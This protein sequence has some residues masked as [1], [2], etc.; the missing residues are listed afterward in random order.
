MFPSKGS[1]VGPGGR[2]LGPYHVLQIQI[3]AR[4]DVTSNTNV[5][6]PPCVVIFSLLS[7]IRRG[8]RKIWIQ[9]MLV[10]MNFDMIPGI[11]GCSISG[12]LQHFSFKRLREC[13]ERGV[14]VC[15]SKET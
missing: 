7:R 4:M 1:G 8:L 9:S 15:S 2:L 3:P 5:T 14:C 10:L 11:M 13:A 12:N 6:I